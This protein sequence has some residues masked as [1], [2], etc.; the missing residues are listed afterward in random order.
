MLLKLAAYKFFELDLCID[1]LVWVIPN[2]IERRLNA[3]NINDKGQPKIFQ[4]GFNKA[5]TR[6][7]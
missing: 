3:L 7:L 1:P 4:I 2:I 6:S 5:G